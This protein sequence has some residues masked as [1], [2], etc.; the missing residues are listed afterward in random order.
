MAAGVTDRVWE[1]ADIVKLVEER[2]SAIDNEVDGEWKTRDGSADLTEGISYGL[3]NNL[4]SRNDLACYRTRGEC[5][6]PQVEHT[7]PRSLQRVVSGIFRS[8]YLKT[9]ET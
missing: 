4:H 2:Q 3:D 6:N 7:T 5:Q 8:R 1:I 9:Y